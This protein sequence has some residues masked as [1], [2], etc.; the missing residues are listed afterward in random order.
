M[1]CNQH[2][3]YQLDKQCA[4]SV[5][6]WD[7][8]T[9][10]HRPI[11]FSR[12]TPPAKETG[13]RP[14]TSK[15]VDK[16]GWA[17]RVT[18]HFN[19]LAV[20]DDEI[21][22]PVRRLV[23]LKDA[24]HIVTN[25]MRH[26]S[27]SVLEETAAPDDRLGYAMSCLRALE[28][29]REATVAKCCKAYPKLRDWIPQPN[30]LHN[31]GKSAG[32]IRDH[33]IELAREQIQCDIQ[34]LSQ[35]PEADPEDR[36]RSKESI[37]KKLKRLAPGETSTINA[38]CDGSG[39]VQTSPDEIANVLKQH[40]EGVFKHKEVNT[41]A[42]Q[43]WMEELFVQSPQGCFVTG[44]PDK[45]SRAWVIKRK[46]MKHAIKT[47]RDS[48][49]GPDGIPSKAYKLLGDF[50]VD[51][52]YDV[53][54]CLG[55]AD[56]KD[57]IRAA[58]SDR[59]REGLHD[60]NL[61]LLCCLPKKPHGVDPEH[62]EFFAGEDTR[63]LALVNTDNRII[64]SSARITWEP[65]LAQ[66]ISDHQQGFLKGRQMLNNV[67]SIDY[68][69]MTVSLKYGRGAL[70][71]FDFK[72]AFPS[73]AHRYLHESLQALGLPDHALALIQALYD[74]N[75]CN[76]SFK[77][78]TY[79]GFGMF[80]G[81]RQGCPIS[82]LLFAA[83]IDVLLRKLAHDMPLSS[84]RAFADDIGAVLT[85]WDTDSVIAEQI[86]SDFAMMSGLDL[87][88][89]KTICIPLWE[90]GMDDIRQSLGTSNRAWSDI[91]VAD[92]GTYLGFIEGPGRCG[93][94]YK[95]PISK[96]AQRCK[97]WGG[98]GGGLQY[99][100]IA[101]N[102]FA[103][104]TLA[105]VAQLET[106]TEDVIDA[107]AAGIRAVLPGPGNWCMPVDAF[108]LKELYGQATSFRSLRLVAQAAKLRTLYTHDCYRRR[109]GNNILSI[110]AMQ[111]HLKY[112]L[113]NTA[114]PIRAYVWKEWYDSSHAMCLHHNRQ[115]LQRIGIST[116]TVLQQIAGTAMPPW[117]EQ[118]RKKQR[119]LFQKI[120]LT[121]IKNHYRPDPIC[122]IREKVSRWFDLH[123]PG[124]RDHS[125]GFLLAGPPAHIAG[126]I[127]RHLL[128]LPT[129]VPPRVCAAVWRVLFNGWCTER[130]YQRRRSTSNV[131]VLGCSGDAEDSIEHYCCCPVIQDTLRHKLR[132]VVPNG[133][134][135][136]FWMLNERFHAREEYLISSALIV[137]ASY[138]A[139]NKYRH[140]G[141]ATYDRAKDALGQF[142]IQGVAGHAAATAFLDHRWSKPVSHLI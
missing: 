34:S 86:F 54:I 119:S 87:N 29:G 100:T 32:H 49:P 40:W 28:Q 51:I 116:E 44:L 52:L 98:T 129:L 10:V 67:I 114:W 97:D 76:I 130:R 42:L 105:F 8:S 2:L 23:L 124:P 110:E 39:R 43:I 48:M 82:P 47:S 83:S 27:P 25:A 73:I 18:S 115:Q 138:M 68:E 6:E 111:D 117:D 58:Y 66:Y 64:A 77:G 53:A 132:I 90:Q 75:S 60:F 128:L 79:E 21:R 139:T 109:T 84:F 13:Q 89:K 125:I 65:I 137:Y 3:S 63:P 33:V 36:A 17:D 31:S 131:C 55:Q 22:N 85:E 37:L 38:M 46:S 133:Q 70:L 118:T 81:V 35:N 101:Y 71:F 15:D 135:L 24:I 20:G 104:S 112:L 14:I 62:G 99:T 106:P 134:A 72:A 126:R 113:C 91:A 96:F 30:V 127:H 59:C 93:Q 140:K 12:R 80:C 56:H 88:I 92:R 4:A 122:R 74:N 103:S 26:D 142:L 11:S 108:Y 61:S 102:I 107:E 50:A 121:H 5:L 9:S 19:T 136:S 78:K 57:T 16:A 7:K 1:Y 69:A 45:C 123:R 94:A 95:K 120:V 41:L 141:R